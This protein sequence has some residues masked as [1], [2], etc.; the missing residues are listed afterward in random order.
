M[1][2]QAII[3]GI[4]FDPKKGSVKIVLIGAS[5]VS[6]DELTTI[7]PKDKSIWVTLESEQTRFDY[8]PKPGGTIALSEEQGLKLKEV[9]ERLGEGDVDGDEVEA[10]G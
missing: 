7:G 9:A 6:L 1:R 10:G 8:E 2:F 3:D 5:H 4:H